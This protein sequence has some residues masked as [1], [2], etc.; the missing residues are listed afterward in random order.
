MATNDLQLVVSGTAA[1]NVAYWSGVQGGSS[2]WGD[3]GASTTNWDT[4]QTG[5]TDTG[6]LPGS[7]TDVVFANLNA[8]SASLNTMLETSY[9][10]NSLTILGSGQTTATTG[11]VTSIGG[12]GNLTLQAAASAAGGLG[13]SAGTGIVVQ[14]GSAGLNI[15]TTG[16]VIAAAAQSWTNKSANSLTVS[17][18]V[19]GS[20]SASNPE[21]LT[22]TNTSTGGTTISGT[23]ADGSGSGSTLALNINNTGSGVTTL[24]GANTYSGQTSI[25]AGKLDLSNSSAL[26]NSTL[27]YTLANSLIFDSSVSSD[28]FT[29]GGL[30]G[31]T[32]LG[33]TNNA[34][35]AVS[36]SVGNN[37]SSTTFSGVLSG[38]GSLNKVGSGTLTL[39]N[40]ESYTGGTIV[41]TGTLQLGDG[42]TNN[43]SVAGNITD[44][45]TLTFAN[46]NPQIYANVISGTGAVN[47]NGPGNL[48]LTNANMYS[49][50]TNVNAGTL[51]LGD[52]VVNNGSVAGNIVDNTAV[53]FANPNNE[54]YAGAISGPG[55]VTAAGM[56]TLEFTGANTYYGNTNVNP[57]ATL[58][59]GDGV[60]NNGSLAGNTNLSGTLIFANP[61]TQIYSGIISGTGSVIANGPG[62]LTL[63][64]AS[65]YSGPT[66]INGGTVD[67][68]NNTALGT[69]TVTLNGQGATG[70]PVLTS[71]NAA[72]VIFSNNIVV[73]SGVSYLGATA[74][75]TY[76]VA[77]NLS[78]SGTLYLTQPAGGT[79][80]YVFLSGNNSGFSGSMDNYG[81]S[82]SRFRF[83]AA[84]AGSAN[85][86]FATYDA[87]TDSTSFNF[88]AGTISFGSLSGTGYIRQDV[89][90][91]ANT[92][93]LA[94]GALGQYTQFSGT[95]NT[96]FQC[97]LTL[98]VVG[99]GTLEMEGSNIWA[100]AAESTG[101]SS[102][103]IIDTPI[104]NVTTVNAN[105]GTIDF[106]NQ[107]PFTFAATQTLMGQGTIL[108]T[109]TADGP[110]SIGQAV[111][112]AGDIAST[113]NVASGSTLALSLSEDLTAVNTADDLVFGGGTGSAN[114]G[115]TL[116]IYDPNNIA[117]AGGQDYQI[118]GFGS[119]T[120]TFTSITLP[121]LAANLSWNTSQ[122][123]TE[124]LLSIISSG[125]PSIYWD[126]TGAGSPTN[127]T[128]W[129]TTNNNWN[130]GSAA[131]TYADG[132]NITFND[133]NAGN[134]S[135][136]LN[137]TVSPGSVTVNS[138]GNYSITGAGTILDAGA[139]NKTGTSTLTLGVG[140]TAASMAITGGNVV[141]A[142]NT[143]SGTWTAAHPNSNINLTSLTIAPNSVLD[144][145][146]NHI[147]ID[148]GSSDPISTI[149][150]YLKSGFNNG[151][152]NGTTG[153]IS[154]TAQSTTNGLHYGVGWADGADGTHNVAGLSSGEI[155]LKY[156]LLGDANLDGTVNGSDFSVLAANFGLG[157]TNWDQGNFLYGSSVNGS[158]F[159]AL[160]ANF[161]QGDSG[162]A[163]TVTP[164]DI[165]ALDAFAAANNL[166]MPTI[167]AVPE[168]AT[169]GLL[170]VG[171]ASLMARKRRRSR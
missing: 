5:A 144:I 3:H 166:P 146:N 67:V 133:T 56:G 140:L 80:G 158:D 160:A 109:I 65:T 153:I 43:G 128:S 44:D 91:I 57:T 60:S 167:A 147:I 116:T 127:G 34:S 76:T 86:S 23:I 83:T 30:S 114:L 107:S 49:G 99:G 134:Y 108:G 154:S 20:S 12:S 125:P 48:T 117:F 78:G 124:G 115:G 132:D 96:G 26:Q 46:P 79:F 45:A 98:N 81:S 130:S 72:G 137:S 18:N 164:A 64:G 29:L 38:G 171:S 75:V 89:S 19:A 129:D 131:T 74:N 122:L 165:A 31:S 94:V 87:G 33:L 138:S 42:V 39:N 159:S 88:G 58:Q 150:G 162:A 163:A 13:Y 22:L 41:S 118:L 59:L 93:T 51:Q 53:V 8:T 97:Y 143:T 15:N 110:V 62:Y 101:A 47:V 82:N 2:N 14:S 4:T 27:S 170:A 35:A 113:L 1:P 136:T 149:Y 32:N 24:S 151:A 104:N 54:T 6:Q 55:S 123:Y 95:L 36:L 40:A 105:G 69:G 63:Q 168:P 90:G 156:T 92:S 50:V 66:T 145:T 106:S 16:T 119:E 135:V 126:N 161:G 7:N 152:W 52:G 85:A 141:L 111:N 9:S 103:L 169:I 17:S 121:T 37:S 73:G 84:T 157:V 11:T 21:T 100:G 120:G 112:T 28:A 70:Y 25:T 155:E 71:S 77:G 102:D 142:G 139:F 148:Y 10:I 68:S 61:N